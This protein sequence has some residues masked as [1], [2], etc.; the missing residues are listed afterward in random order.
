MVAIGNNKN[1]DFDGIHVVRIRSKDTQDL[2]R[3]AGSLT[4]N[5]STILSTVVNYIKKCIIAEDFWLLNFPLD[6]SYVRVFTNT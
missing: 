6:E 5:Y 4:L 3:C 1:K 2:Y